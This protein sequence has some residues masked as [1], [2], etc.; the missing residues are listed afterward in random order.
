[1][2]LF[3]AAAHEVL[4]ISDAY[5]GISQSLFCLTARRCSSWAASSDTPKRVFKRCEFGQMTRD[6]VTRMLGNISK[7]LS[8]IQAGNA[9]DRRRLP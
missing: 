3:N 2:Y 5:C 7:S 6:I 4:P 8:T 1:M 9:D